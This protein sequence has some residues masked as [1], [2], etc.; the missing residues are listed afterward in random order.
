MHLKNLAMTTILTPWLMLPAPIFADSGAL[1]TAA[2]QASLTQELDEYVS[3]DSAGAEKA[4]TNIR[5]TLSELERRNVRLSLYPSTLTNSEFQRNL[6][7]LIRTESAK[8]TQTA[9]NSNVTTMGKLC[10]VGAIVIALAVSSNCK[11]SGG[12]SKPGYSNWHTWTA[13]TQ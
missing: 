1:P 12:I 13:T 11:G 2:E 8:K 3:A 10:L 5:N 9:D 7:S 4:L 6:D